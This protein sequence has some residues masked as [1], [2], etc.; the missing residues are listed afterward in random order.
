M[1][2][3]QFGEIFSEARIRKGFTKTQLS[4]AL[5]VTDVSVYRY[6]K[7]EVPT[8]NILKKIERVL[9][10]DFNIIELKQKKPSF[11][12]LE[13]FFSHLGKK[14]PES[15]K[16]FKIKFPFMEI[17]DAFTFFLENEI[18]VQYGLVKET[19][20]NHKGSYFIKIV[21]R[22]KDYRE[23]LG[24]KRSDFTYFGI[25]SEESASINAIEKGFK[26]MEMLKTGKKFNGKK[27]K[28]S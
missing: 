5:N 25:L 28:A 7:G 8:Q 12:K 27:A 10:L 11:D 9:D 23:Q 24:K 26:I 19:R 6:E 14:Y 1:Q 17:N 3:P 18:E 13:T 4:R 16:A 2:N 21:L 20:K 15:F 22:N